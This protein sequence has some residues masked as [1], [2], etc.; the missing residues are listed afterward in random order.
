MPEL[1]TV[2]PQKTAGFV[3]RTRSK[4][5]DKI[6]R[7]EQELKELLAQSQGEGVQET[8]EESQDVS[9]PEEGKEK[10]VPDETLSKEE[11]SFKTRYGD[12]RRHMA[13]KEKEFNARIKELEDQ[14]SSTKKL[15]P[16]K[17]DEDITK[18]ANEYPDVAG[19]VETIAEK[20]AKEMFEKANIQIEELSKAR[21]E[22]TR[23]TAENEIKEIHKDF[24]KLRDSDEFH[25]WVEEQPKWVQ[26]ALYENTDDAKSVVRVIDLYKIDKGLTAG[27]KKNKTKAAASLVNKTSKTKVDAEELADTVKE[28]DVEKMSDSDYAKNVD[29]INTA[30]RSGK[31]IYDISGNRR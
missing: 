30:I 12:V 16:P 20:K 31:F 3:S 15:V 5:K 19:I 25:E 14:L 1:E 21:Q 24:D 26:N 6:A 18:W 27:D 29:K 28:S 11:K 7:E 9:P 10:E 22:T 8:S 17:S 23:R 13:A 4:Y 2:E